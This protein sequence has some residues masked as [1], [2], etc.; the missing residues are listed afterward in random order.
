M[1]Q[2]KQKIESIFK[3][4]IDDIGD[5]YDAKDEFIK[6]INAVLKKHY[7]DKDGV[8]CKKIFEDARAAL[9]A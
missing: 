9:K 2:N 4:Y 1:K 5:Y 3:K 7:G 8:M 6:D